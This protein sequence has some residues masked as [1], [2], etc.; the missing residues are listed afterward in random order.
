MNTQRPWMNQKL[1]EWSVCQP[2][3]GH[4]HGWLNLQCESSRHVLDFIEPLVLS[5][6][7]DAFE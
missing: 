1:V 7:Q 3:A 2:G 6:D 5:V 4:P